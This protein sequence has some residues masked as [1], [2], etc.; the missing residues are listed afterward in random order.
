M[1]ASLIYEKRQRI[2]ECIRRLRQEVAE[3]VTGEFLRRHPSWL[4]QYGGLARE[5]GVEDALYHVDFLAGAIESGSESA[6][7]DYALWTQ[8][9]LGSRGIAAPFLVENLEQIREALRDRLAGEESSAV[10][11]FVDAACSAVRARVKAVDATDPIRVERSLY[12]QTV[13]GGH[14]QPALN[15]ALQ[16]LREGVSVPE[17][18]VDLLQP[19]QYEIGRMWERNE[20]TVAREHLATAITQFVV[21]QLYTRL[22]VPEV[23]QGNAIITGVEGELHQLGANMVA[24]V[25]EAE[26][27]DVRFLG[28][29]MPRRDILRTIEEHEATLIGIS[30]TMLF[31]L[32]HVSGLIEDVR[33][34]FGRETR[35]LVG[36]GAFRSSD[37]LWK[38]I[39]ADAFG[40]D[41][42]SAVAAAQ[43]LFETSKQ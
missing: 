16:L 1:S 38:E 12:L 25:L 6:F 22:E 34:T 43:S 31:N 19:A 18:Y 23:K 42:R 35:I 2:A 33:R 11:R 24:D 8:R 39:G 4:R 40:T 21:S 9:V 32:P 17:I 14:R 28:T 3:E 13:L 26:G 20:I 10:A 15:V 5:R 37:D 7:V 36:G 29:Q 41:L 30:T 27:W